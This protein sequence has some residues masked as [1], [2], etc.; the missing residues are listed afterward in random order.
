MSIKHTSSV[1]RYVACHAD[2]TAALENLA[3]FVDSLPAPAEDGSLPTLHY[4]HLGTLEE[5]RKQ[6]GEA[7]R[8]ADKFCKN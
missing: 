3:E 2:L 8:L 5:I 7:M 6:L 1:D 4:G